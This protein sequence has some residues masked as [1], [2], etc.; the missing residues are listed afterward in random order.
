M[1]N[2][3][4]WTLVSVLVIEGIIGLVLNNTIKKVGYVI[5]SVGYQVEKIHETEVLTPQENSK[6]DT[7]LALCNSIKQ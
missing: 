5:C 1:K 2:W 6:L 4:F 3:Q 7:A